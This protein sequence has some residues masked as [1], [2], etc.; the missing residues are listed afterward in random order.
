MISAGDGVVGI[1]GVLFQEF[2]K[3]ESMCLHRRTRSMKPIIE[4]LLG[5]SSGRGDGRLMF[6]WR[7]RF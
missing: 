4:G 5:S 1:C 3:G 6:A 7:F 2:R